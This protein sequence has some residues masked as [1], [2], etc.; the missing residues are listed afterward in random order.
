MIH[1]DLY[2]SVFI[3]VIFLCYLRLVSATPNSLCEYPAWASLR[4]CAAYCLGCDSRASQV[5]YIIGCQPVPPNECYCATDLFAQ[6]TSF[7]S[8]CVSQSC[9]VGPWESD[10]SG[11]QSVYENYCLGAGFTAVADSPATTSVTPTV[12]GTGPTVTAVT[13]VTE[14]VASSSSGA[15][16]SGGE[17]LVFVALVTAI[18]A[19][20]PL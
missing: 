6:A 13:L 11:A 1:S 10:Y 16:N 8:T 19:A 18:M 2:N 14:T 12:E 3:S 5:G 4:P 15:V 9:T 20:F 17:L 7:I